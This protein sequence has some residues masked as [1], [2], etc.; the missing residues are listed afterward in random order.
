MKYITAQFLMANWFFIH[1]TIKHAAIQIT[2]L[3]VITVKT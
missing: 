1:A 2:Y 3:L